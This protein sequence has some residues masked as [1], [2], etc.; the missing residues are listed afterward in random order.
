MGEWR[1]IALGYMTVARECEPLGGPFS[2]RSGCRVG[3]RS[4]M[5][6][7]AFAAV[8]GVVAAVEPGPFGGC[9]PGACGPTT[10]GLE[11]RDETDQV[12]DG[13]GWLSA[14]VSRRA[15]PCKGPAVAFL[16]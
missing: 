16:S 4:A 15:G 9:Q 7:G 6:G 3:A 2:D 8:S 12:G 1:K 10:S 5:H 13:Q 14:R 11:P